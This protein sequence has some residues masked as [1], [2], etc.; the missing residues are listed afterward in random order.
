MPTSPAFGLSIA[1]LVSLLFAHIIGNYV[2]VKNSYSRWKNISKFKMPTSAK[3]LFFISWY[4]ISIF[5][6]FML[7]VVTLN[8]TI[9]N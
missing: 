7:L 5:F 6:A 4:D 3:V 9:L 8:L 1:T 2:L